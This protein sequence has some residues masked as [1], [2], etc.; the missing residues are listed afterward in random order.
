MCETNIVALHDQTPQISL[1]D[2]PF[3]RSRRHSRHDDVFLS[4]GTK[5]FSS[6][7][8]FSQ[9]CRHKRRDVKKLFFSEK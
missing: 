2:P 3:L 6:S 9:T 7:S 5:D 8:S 1:P 4:R